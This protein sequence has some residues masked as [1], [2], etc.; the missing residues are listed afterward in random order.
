MLVL[1]LLLLVTGGILLNWAQ[2]QKILKFSLST[3]SI[4]SLFLKNLIYEFLEGKFSSEW[5][6][7]NRDRIFVSETFFACRC[8]IA[9]IATRNPIIVELQFYFLWEMSWKA[10]WLRIESVPPVMLRQHVMHNNQKSK[11]VFLK[12]QCDSNPTFCYFQHK[13]YQ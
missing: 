4:L 1:L 10:S 3:Y 9:L 12:F 6:K 2:R 5:C 7:E 11:V 8:K 13:L